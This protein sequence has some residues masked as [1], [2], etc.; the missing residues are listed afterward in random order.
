MAWTIRWARTARIIALVVYF[1]SAFTTL[2]QIA[3]PQP[4][5]RSV[6][7]DWRAPYARFL[8]ALG[9]ADVTAIVADTKFS[10]MV[11][12]HG[13]N[14][15][16][17]RIEHKSAC[18]EDVCLS[19]IGHLVG[20]NFVSGALFMGG[21]RLGV[22]DQTFTWLGLEAVPHALLSSKGSVGLVET[23]EGWIVIPLK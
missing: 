16:L 15:A 7:D 13:P 20:D 23:S 5:T 6:P 21:G 9:V 3:E 2:A 12:I 1:S 8:S 17:F 4:V 22:S 10:P 11:S 18:Q 14:S 19:V